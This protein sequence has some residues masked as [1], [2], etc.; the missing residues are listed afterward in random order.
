MKVL[1]DEWDGIENGELLTLA[2]DQFDVFIT[3]DRN[4]SF[5]QNIGSFKI[6]VLVLR[7]GGTRMQDLTSVLPKLPTACADAR[8]GTLHFIDG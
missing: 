6:A 2:Q 5:Q 1:V 7:C 3:G 4:L 8:P